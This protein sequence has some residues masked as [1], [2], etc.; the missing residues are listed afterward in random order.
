MQITVSGGDYGWKINQTQE[1]EELFKNVME[2]SQLGREPIYAQ[3]E[4]STENNG[5]GNTYVEIDLDGAAF[6]LLSERTGCGG[7]ALCFW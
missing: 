1:V 7:F 6:V 3:R 2:N 4:V 5:I